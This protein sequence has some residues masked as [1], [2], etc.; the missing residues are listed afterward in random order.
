MS[1]FE[2]FDC[3]RDVVRATK[4]LFQPFRPTGRLRIETWNRSVLVPLVLD[5]I[6]MVS[7]TLRCIPKSS[8]DWLIIS[9]PDQPMRS[10]PSCNTC[11]RPSLFVQIHCHCPC[12]NLLSESSRSHEHILHIR[13][14]LFLLFVYMHIIQPPPASSPFICIHIPF[15][16]LT[17]IHP[18]VAML[19]TTS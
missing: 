2:A 7:Q 15:I 5:Y 17:P 14:H 6:S 13:I 1:F 19:V 10:C 11:I 9:T 8:Q 3:S 16:S 4:D 18:V 12:Y